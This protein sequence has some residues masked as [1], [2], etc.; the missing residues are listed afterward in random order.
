M[1]YWPKVK[2]WNDTTGLTTPTHI[3]LDGNQLKGV[4]SIEYRADIDSIPTI[5]LELYCLLDSGI[6]LDNADLR[7]KF[8]PSTIE[9][10]VYI[11]DKEFGIDHKDDF[12]NFVKQRYGVDIE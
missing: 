11:L 8:H 9:E 10:A 2:I 3:S 6:D 1:S 4:H 12:K 5:T 7:L